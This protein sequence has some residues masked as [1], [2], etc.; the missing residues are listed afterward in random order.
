MPAARALL[1]TADDF[2]IGPAT[3]R[4]IL[5]LAHRGIVTSTVMLVNS[6]FAAESVRMWSRAGRPLELGWH[7]CLTLDAPLLPPSEV[8]SLVESNGCFPRLGTF[9]KRLM[10]GRVK[11]TEIEAEFRAQLRRFVQLVGFAPANVNAHHHVHIFRP[12]SEALATV[13]G[14]ANFRP[15]LRRVSEPRRTLWRVPGARLKRA[16]LTKY[17]QRAATRQAAEGFPGNDSLIGITDPPCVRNPFF[18]ER[19]L[20]AA[21][22]QYVELSCHPGCYDITLA[23][24]DGTPFDGQLH[25]RQH[26]YERLAIDGML[27]VIAAAGFQPVS[28]MEMVNRMNGANAR[29]SR[30]RERRRVTS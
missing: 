17:G 6:P 14:E 18:F 8:P 28:A 15:F 21:S 30:T 24:R 9:L 16:F 23:G 27:D 2:G 22:G 20:R 25:R 19:W 12:V 13:L 5:D 11:R 4:G 1:I 26:E 29:P 7:P 3:S 10:F